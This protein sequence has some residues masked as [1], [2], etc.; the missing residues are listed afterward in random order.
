MF[1]RGAAAA[2][3]DTE[4]RSSISVSST[5]TTASAPSGIGAPVAISAHSPPPIWLFGICPVID[6]LDAPQRPRG[7][8]AGSDGVFGPDGIAVHRGTREWRH[9]DR[10]D[11]VLASTRP[12]AL[13]QRKDLGAIDRHDGALD[14]RARLLERNRLPEGAHLRGQLQTP[15]YQLPTP[16][17][18]ST[19]RT[20]THNPL[21]VG[22]WALGVDKIHLESC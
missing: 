17:Q 16:K 8:A 22:N 13:L 6:R 15:N 21:G 1:C 4:P 5:I 20:V 18:P 11:D 9:V 19:S 7:R 14:D 10:R 2:K 3:I 12:L